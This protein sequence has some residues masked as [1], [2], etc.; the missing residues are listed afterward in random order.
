MPKR[1]LIVDDHAPIRAI[2]RDFLLPIEH[3]EVCGEAVDGLDALEKVQL[4]SPD[5]I[6]LDLSMPRMNGLQ[7]ARRLRAS[8]VRAPIVLFTL[9]ANEIRNEDA[10][11]AGISAV[12]SKTDLPQL[13]KKIGELLPT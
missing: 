9:Y 5:L 13:R 1:I 3:W 6:L 12:V 11:A 10:V 4:L 2:V 7:A 8:K